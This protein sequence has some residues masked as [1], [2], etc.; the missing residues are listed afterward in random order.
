[1]RSGIIKFKSGGSIQTFVSTNKKISPD[2]FRYNEILFDG[3]S[4]TNEIINKFYT[5][6]LVPY[7]IEDPIDNSSDDSDLNKFL[8]E[9]KVIN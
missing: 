3:N 6:L 4:F 8:N 2:G 9:F 7:V 1:M 5:P